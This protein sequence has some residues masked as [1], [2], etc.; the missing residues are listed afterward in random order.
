MLVL[1]LSLSVLLVGAVACAVDTSAV[2]PDARRP[3]DP[4]VPPPLSDAG[5]ADGGEDAD[6]IDPP[7][8]P[9]PLRDDAADLL[10]GWHDQVARSI[11]DWTLPEA[12]A[13]SGYVLP[14]GTEVLAVRVVPGAEAP[15][16]VFYEAGGGA[17]SD[18]FWPASTIKLLAAIGALERVKEMGFSSDA[19]VSFDSG[20]ANPLSAIVERAI[21]VSSNEDY[22]RTVRIAGLARLNDE[23]LTPGRGFPFTAIQASYSGMGVTSSPGITLVE[24]ARREHVPAYSGARRGRCPG[25]G[26]NC[27][28]L[29]ELFE[30]ARRLLLDAEIPEHERFAIAP[31]D[32][33]LLRRS[34]C[35]A[36]PSFFQPGVEH[37]LGPDAA[38]CHKPGWVPTADCLDHGM[39][40]D[41]VTGDRVF[42]AAASPAEGRS[43]CPM[44]APLAEEVLFALGDAHDGM[45]LGPNEGRPI[46]VQIDVAPEG[47]RFTLEAEGADRVVLHL[48]G[49]P[50]GDASG[51]GR[52]VVETQIEARGERLLGIEAFR[53]GAVVGRRTAVVRL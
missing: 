31:N 47:D 16:Y 41:R 5:A 38:V 14:P 13:E 51:E 28:T 34:L 19:F 6:P 2:A 22:D 25:A 30:G 15:G 3:V 20:Y 21:R 48:D 53:D 23:F 43:D 32:V 9:P 27:T 40:V 8:P 46:V 49:W 7:P 29:F 10:P 24:G 39:I 37:V 52:F 1:R 35:E 33:E 18:D 42:L 44:L 11:D 17:F 36:T 4:P 12:F 45:A 50:V 26:N